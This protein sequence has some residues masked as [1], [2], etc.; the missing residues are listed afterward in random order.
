[1]TLPDGK[2]TDVALGTEGLDR[3]RIGLVQS[4]LDPKHFAWAPATDS[5]RAPYRGL[6]DQLRKQD[7]NSKPLQERTDKTDSTSRGRV[8]SV[9]S[10]GDLGEAGY[11]TLAPASPLRAGV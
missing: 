9:L 4:G 8:L 5:D 10:V 7:E 2:T 3:L 1:M 11:A 6:L